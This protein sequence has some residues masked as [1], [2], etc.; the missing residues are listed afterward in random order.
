LQ[1]LNSASDLREK[2]IILL[3]ASTGMRAGALNTLTLGS[4]EKTEVEYHSSHIYKIIVYEQ[5]KENYYCFTTFEC[6]AM[7]DQYL[8]FR[9][10]SGEI[11][12]KDSPLIREEFNCSDRFAVVRPKFLHYKSIYTIIERLLI[13]TGIRSRSN[14]RRH[15][16]DVMLSHGFRKFNITQLKKARVDFSDREYLVGHKHTRG[17]DV[18]YDRTTEEDRLHEYLKAMDLLTISPENRLRKQV[19]EQEYT[20]QHKLA[21]KDKQIEEMIRKQEQFEQLIQ[22]LID[23]G[24]LKPTN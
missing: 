6:A 17:L 3:L 19:T 22:S 20:I 24:Q 12:T 23:S 4:L 11:L 14:I 9:Q 18:N 16:H 10:R 15:L 2:T 1:I 7:I 21:E 8:Q 5:D 13:L